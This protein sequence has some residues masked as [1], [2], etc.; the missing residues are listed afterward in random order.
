MFMSQAVHDHSTNAAAK[1]RRPLHIKGNGDKGHHTKLAAIGR[2][3]TAEIS[4]F[5]S[6]AGKGGN[7]NGATPFSPETDLGPEGTELTRQQAES[8]VPAG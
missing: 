4:T 8:T 2:R 7:R 3:I 6:E 1:S 5:P